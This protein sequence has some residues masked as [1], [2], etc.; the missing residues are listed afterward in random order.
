MADEQREE[1]TNDVIGRRLVGVGVVSA[2]VI[3]VVWFGQ[4]NSHQE[5]QRDFGA[6]VAEESFNSTPYA[7]ALALAVG[8]V[9]LGL[10]LRGSSR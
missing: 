10:V 3:G 4:W 6:F 9:I 8:V 5:T 7:L 1:S 2:V